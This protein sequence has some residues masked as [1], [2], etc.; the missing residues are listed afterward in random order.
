MRFDV[1]TLFPAM[2][3]IVRGWG[4]TGKALERGI[5][6]LRAWN[7]RDYTVATLRTRVETFAELV[8][9]TKAAKTGWAT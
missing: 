1:V 8:R 5:A 6:R 3:D 7:P 9:M 4:V 2:F